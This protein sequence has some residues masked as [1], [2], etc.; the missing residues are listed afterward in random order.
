M[1]RKLDEDGGSSERVVKRSR[2]SFWAT[3]E[4]LLEVLE[5][6]EPSELLECRQV[7]RQWRR[8]V[9]D[10]SVCYLL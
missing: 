8:L 6:L 2:R 3:E 9:S 7:C 1:K 10:E 4:L 5:Y